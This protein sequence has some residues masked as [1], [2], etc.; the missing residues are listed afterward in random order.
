MRLRIIDLA[1]GD[2]PISSED[3]DVILVFNGEIYNHE[4]LRYSLRARGRQFVSSSD[5]EVVLHAFREWDV[6]CFHRLRGMFALAIWIRSQKRL[7]LARDRMGIKPLYFC[8][9]GSDLLF[10]SEIKAIFEDPVV[11]RQIDINALNCFLRLNYVPAP[12]TMVRGIE[13]L[14][15]GHVMEWTDGQTRS[16]AY[17][18]SG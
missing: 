15:P 9:A 11:E 12:Y 16:H 1:G 8:H 13:K 2:Q 6:D 14:A 18:E 4:E 3:G 5:T 17:W 7:V 10:G